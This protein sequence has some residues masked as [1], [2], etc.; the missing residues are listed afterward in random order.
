ML[1]TIERNPRRFENDGTPYR[2][3]HHRFD[4]E[5]CTGC[6]SWYLMGQF[7]T[8]EEAFVAIGKAFIETT[9]PVERG[10]IAT[11]GVRKIVEG[12]IFRQPVIG[13]D[14]RPTLVDDEEPIP[15][16]M[17]TLYSTPWAEAV[18]LVTIP[19]MPA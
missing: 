18:K 3:L 1:E 6:T 9:C 12:S 14:G 2:V 7:A 15:N 8:A 17:K 5:H 10:E 13:A 4:S 19:G 11:Y 16:W